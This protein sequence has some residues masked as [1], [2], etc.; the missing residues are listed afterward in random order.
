MRHKVRVFKLGRRPDHVRALLANQVCSLIMHG[1][2]RTTVVKAKETRRLAERMLTWAKRG[3][4]H[5]RRMAIAKL[6]NKEAVAKLFDEIAQLYADRN[7]GYTR[8]IKLGQRRGDGAQ[9]CL[10]EWLHVREQEMSSPDEAAQ[11]TEAQPQDNTE[12][13]AQAEN[14][15]E[16]EAGEEA[17]A[18]A[19]SGDEGKSEAN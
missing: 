6:H 5:H 9:L 2:I 7:G 18:E 13:E 17:Q 10:L 4:L 15:A 12:A 11:D 16:A 19:E 14:S 3:T 8:I 1:R